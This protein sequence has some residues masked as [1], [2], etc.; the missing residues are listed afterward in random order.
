VIGIFIAQA[1]G[2]ALGIILYALCPDLLWIYFLSIGLSVF[3]FLTLSAVKVPFRAPIVHATC[4]LDRFFLPRAIGLSVNVLLFAVGISLVIS[5]N[6]LILGIFWLSVLI[7]LVLFLAVLFAIPDL[8]RMYIG[9][10]AH[11]Q[12]CTINNTLMLTWISGFFLGIVLA[13]Y[14][15]TLSLGCLDFVALGIIVLAV[16]MYFTLTRWLYR[17]LK[18]RDM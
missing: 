16:L 8:L 11:C 17:K 5:S 3:S 14:F 9:L 7:D 15:S 1:I 2:Y 10:T 18:K 4:S 13:S 12:R 6:Y